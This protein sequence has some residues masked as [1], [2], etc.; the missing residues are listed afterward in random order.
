MNT[1]KN[2]IGSGLLL[3]ISVI[4]ASCG[5]DYEECPF[6]GVVVSNNYFEPLDSVCFNN[7]IVLNMEVTE[8]HSFKDVQHGSHSIA[9]YTK[10]KLKI[11][12]DIEL[13]GDSNCIRIAL[14]ESGRIGIK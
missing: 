4:F 12:A 3:I 7:A 11:T 14:T 10:S 6:Y 9:F 5:S 13:A 8:Q 2:L 1:I